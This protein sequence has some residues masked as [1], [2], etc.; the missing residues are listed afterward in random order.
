VAGHV[1]LELRNVVAKYPFE[2]SHRFPDPAEFWPQRLFGFEG[3]DTQLG[4]RAKISAGVFAPA[5][6][7]ALDRA[8]GDVEGNNGA[9]IE[10]VAW[11][12]IAEPR[13]TVAGTPGGRLVSGS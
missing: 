2:S 5:L 9:G 1:R 10:I 8:A 4:P 6:E 7:V 12:L 13:A 3:G 11:T